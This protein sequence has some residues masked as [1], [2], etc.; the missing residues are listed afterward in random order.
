VWRVTLRPGVRFQDGSPLNAS[1]VLANARRWTATGAAD[2]LLPGL[3]AVDAPRPDEV[4]FLFR[5]PRAGVPA[6][7]A[8]PRLGIVSPR[9]LAAHGGERSAPVTLPAGSGTGP[10]ELGERSRG[11]VMLAR[12]GGWWGSPAGLGPALDAV[13]FVR[14][15]TAAERVARL[16]AGEAQVAEPLGRGEAAAV[17]A[18]PLLRAV[19]LGAGAG[20]AGMEASVRGFPAGPGIPALSAV[21][22]TRIGS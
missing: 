13:E 15:P 8:S 14:I 7:L 10:F 18:D 11:R 1:A 20:F 9:A 17:V 4:R 21:W 16:S 19:P 6:L 2:G 22:L 3:F 12:D 5:R